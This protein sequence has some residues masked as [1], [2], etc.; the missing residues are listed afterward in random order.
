[1]RGLF[2]FAFV[3]PPIGYVAV[4]F[5]LVLT[6]PFDPSPG[7]ESVINSMGNALLGFLLPIG[8]SIAYFIGVGPAAATGT[9]FGLVKGLRTSRRRTIVV[10]TI[11]G[12]AVSAA[13]PLLLLGPSQPNTIGSS[14]WTV[15]ILAAVGA[16]SALA[17][18]WF[19]T[20]QRTR[21]R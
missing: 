9:V 2:I 13:F 8:W 12:A 6:V 16:V 3:G 10:T 21:N 19:F 1:M 11:C 7:S 17:C 5:L 14:P 18:S 15:V 20:R 4:I